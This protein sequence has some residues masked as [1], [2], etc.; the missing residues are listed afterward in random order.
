MQK[1]VSKT[2][3]KSGVFFEERDGKE[4]TTVS[5]AGTR[6]S[7]QTLRRHEKLSRRSSIRTHRKMERPCETQK[8]A[9]PRV[10]VRPNDERRAR[11][12][13]SIP[14]LTERYGFPHDGAVHGGARRRQVFIVQQGGSANSRR[15]RREGAVPRVALC[16]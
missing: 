4:D 15:G 14:M 11:R 2:T 3:R 5:G 12:W 6:V 16:S 7:Q 10:K 8:R 1:C 13:Y 9:R